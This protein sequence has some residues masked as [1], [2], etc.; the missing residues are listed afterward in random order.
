MLLKV[1]NEAKITNFLSLWAHTH[2]C[3]YIFEMYIWN[4]YVCVYVCVCACSVVSN[5]LQPHELYPAGSSV[6]GIFQ[7]RIL[8]WIAI[9]FSRDMCMHDMIS[10]DAMCICKTEMNS[11]RIILLKGSLATQN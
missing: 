7:A 5:S 6:H 8:E 10:S 2:M 11:F 4:I 1:I 3:V 9:S